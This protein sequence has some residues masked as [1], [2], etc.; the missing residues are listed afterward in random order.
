[1][2]ARLSAMALANVTYSDFSKAFNLVSQDTGVSLYLFYCC[3]FR[4]RSFKEL[5][6][7]IIFDQ[8][9]VTSGIS[10]CNHLEPFLFILYINDHQ[11]EINSS[12]I[13]RYVDDIKLL[14]FSPWESHSY[15]L[16][17]DLDNL[18]TRCLPN[19]MKPNLKKCKKLSFSSRVL[20]TTAYLIDS[21]KLDNVYL[22]RDLDVLFD[23]SLRCNFH[24]SVNKAS[25]SFWF[26]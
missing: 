19:F 15:L 6:G 3:Y 12:H 11:R 4:K 2:F 14:F 9:S 18:V 10:Q 24:V 13:L 7:S 21:P 20:F 22:F 25:V 23:R 16:H 1:M 8:F 17:S 5:F 26:Y